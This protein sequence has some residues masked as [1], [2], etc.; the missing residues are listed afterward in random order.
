MAVYVWGT[1]C[2]AGEFVEQ[3]FPVERI[4]AFVDSRPAGESFLGRPVVLPEQVDPADVELMVVASR[5]TASIR[6]ACLAL[7]IPSERL[8]F[9]KNHHVTKDLN[10]NYPLVEAILGREIMSSLRYHCHLIREPM[11]CPDGA[12]EKKDEEN[13]YVRVKTLEL[14]CRRLESVPGAAAEL[15][16]YRGAFARCINMLMPERKLYLFDSFEGFDGAEAA[17]EQNAGTCGEGFLEAHKNTAVGQ[18]LAW[19]PHRERIQV[20]PGFFPA[21]LCGLEERFALVSLDVDFEDTTLEGLRYFWPRMNSGGFI[22]LHDYNSHCLTGV[23]RAVA[24]YEEELGTRLPAVPLCDVNGTLV[25]A[26]G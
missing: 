11:G 4:A 26:K 17:R 3:G 14:L 10:E 6:E 1:G 21:S 12:L 16:V 20:M 13:D 15:G 19:M 24:R 23:S 2:G 9:L 18:V 25:L 8:L 7:G 22:L 5:H